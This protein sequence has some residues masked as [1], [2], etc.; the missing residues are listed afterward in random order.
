M[1]NKLYELDVERTRKLG[2]MTS[3]LLMLA[4]S[5]DTLTRF[6]VQPSTL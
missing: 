1:D 3:V 5:M 2:N 4:F 6:C